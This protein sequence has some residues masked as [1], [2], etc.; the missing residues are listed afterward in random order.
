M[1]KETKKHLDEIREA[2]TNVVGVDIR[3][4]RRIRDTYVYGRITFYKLVKLTT[5]LSDA[6]I[7]EYIGFDRCTVIHGI[8]KFDIH[9]TDPLF[10]DIF[11]EVSQII[12]AVYEIENE[13]EPVL[14]KNENVSSLLQENVKLKNKVFK[15]TLKGFKEMLLSLDAEGIEEA[16]V[17]LKPFVKMY[18]NRKTYENTTRIERG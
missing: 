3:K 2:C 14:I 7:G 6:N 1:N 9:K 12:G 4:A 5:N 15:G 10:V 13:D 18:N 11:N 17:R 16:K 8:N